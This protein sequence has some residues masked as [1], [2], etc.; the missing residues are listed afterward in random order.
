MAQLD[1][2]QIIG[3]AGAHAANSEWAE[4]SIALQLAQL[5]LLARIANDSTV[6]QSVTKYFTKL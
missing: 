6:P 1:L 3:Q 5:F 2:D 4:A